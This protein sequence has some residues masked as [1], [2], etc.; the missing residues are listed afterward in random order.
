MYTADGLDIRVLRELGKDARVSLRRLSRRLGVSITTVSNRL[1][2]MEKAGM[3]R[4]YSVLVDHE[5]MGFDLTAMIELVVSK[6][7][8]MEVE[9]EIAGMK[10]VF[11]VYDI[12]GSTDAVVLARFRKRIEMNRFIKGLLSMRYVERTNTHVVLNV[13]KEDLGPGL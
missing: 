2:R 12:T 3:I 10:N 7:K 8:L 9:R 5:K 1:S 6:G 13:I 11:A 4:G